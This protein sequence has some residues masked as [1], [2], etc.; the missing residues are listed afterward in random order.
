MSRER[1]LKAVNLEPTD[2]VPCN[3]WIDHPG[4]VRKLTGIDP[5]DFPDK[6]IAACIRIL[7]IDWYVG[8][9]HH[10]HR[11][12]AGER[13]KDLGHGRY[14]SEWGFT[15]SG[16][17]MDLDF[18]SD[19]EVLKYRPLERHKPAVRQA[20][21][22]AT[23]AAIKAD[24]DIVGD[25][26]YISGLYYTMLFQWFILTFGWERFLLTAAAEPER[27]KQTIAEFAE[28]SIEYAT[29]FAQT[30]LPV[31]YCHDDIA[32]TRG[33][34]FSPAWY[35]EYIFPH[36]KRIF[37]PL[38]KAGKKIIFVSDGNYIELIDDL[39]AAGVDGCMVDHFVDIENVLRHH[40]GKILIAGN[41]D[42]AKLTFGTPDDVRRDVARCMAYGR[43]YPG[44]MIKVT[45]DLP[46]NI[47]LANIEAYFDA[48][49]EYGVL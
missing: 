2:R 6:A 44:Y 40:G 38:K 3:E 24:Q 11:F 23:I 9:P 1:F 28:L 10:S 16:W 29:Y 12:A 8:L 22:D 46:H 49:K 35:R 39:I 34:V 25:S 30:D 13:K 21:Y 42:I 41:A 4:F 33:L 18:S 45:G 14:V 36:Y 37:A 15:G 31:F 5:F 43:R 32:I 27:F 17:A 47:P 7:D 26:C 48:C 19:E 20:G